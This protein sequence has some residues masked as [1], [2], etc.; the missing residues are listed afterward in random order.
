M[1]HACNYTQTTNP[2]IDGP[3]W[4]NTCDQSNNCIDAE[5]NEKKTRDTDTML[6]NSYL[7]LY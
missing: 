4:A 7:R 1:Q 2:F 5:G 6:C 3:E